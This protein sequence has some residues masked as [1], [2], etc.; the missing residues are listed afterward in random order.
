MNKR[1]WITL[2]LAGTAPSLPTGLVAELLRD[3]HDLVVAGL[4]ARLRPLPAARAQARH[5]PPTTSR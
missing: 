3:S 5:A 1:H 4:P 2:D